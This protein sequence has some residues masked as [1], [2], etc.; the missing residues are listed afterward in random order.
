MKRNKA[1]KLGA[2][3]VIF[4]VINIIGFTIFTVLCIYP[5]Y[6]VV[7]NS[8][9]DNAR[10]LVGQVRLVPVGIH[11]ENYKEAFRIGGFAKATFNSVARTLLGTLVMMLSTIVLGY[12][13]TKKELWGRK[14]WYRFLIVTMYF[15]AGLI[16]GYLN[17][18]RLGLM[19]TFWVYIIPAMV[20]PYNMILVKTY[21]ESIPSSLEE[22]ALMDGASYFKRLVY[23]I[24][25]L[26]KPILAT[27][28]IFSAVGQWNSFMDTV[29]YTQ[30]SELQTLQSVLYLYLNKANTL[31]KLMQSGVSVS[32][33]N[34]ARIP[35]VT[36]IKQTV[37]VIT[38]L[39]VIC[40]YPFFQ[41]YFTKGIMIGA[42]KG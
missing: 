16:P 4:N 29:L 7:I 32:M 31:A 42:V 1:K 27:I 25:P 19:N 35:N 24:V 38:I 20:S 30:G 3:D 5:F 12:A 17:M 9:S 14:F 6:F 13:M 28:A 23:V 18:K 41:R 26:S 21:I 8:I 33:M 34:P 15:S 40:I 10:V 22:A 37:T 2:S 11:F 39:P 36:S